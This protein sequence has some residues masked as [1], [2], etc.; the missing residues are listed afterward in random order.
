MV[1]ALK[2]FNSQG[3]FMIFP[4]PC[5]MMVEKYDFEPSSAFIT[6]HTFQGVG[7]TSLA[8]FHAGVQS[9]GSPGRVFAWCRKPKELQLQRLG[10]V[11]KDGDESKLDKTM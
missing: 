1:G 9:R 3:A 10:L 7:A 11:H 2:S 5:P 6:F 4:S 8:M